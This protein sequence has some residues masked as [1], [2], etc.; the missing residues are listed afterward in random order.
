MSVISVLWM[1]RQ[2]DSQFE[3]SWSYKMRSGLRT[4]SPIWFSPPTPICWISFELVIVPRVEVGFLFIWRL[5]FFGGTGV[6]ELRTLFARQA[7]YHLSHA[8]SPTFLSGKG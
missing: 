3:V 2:V 1:L 7:L 5:I 4:T 8:P 6:F